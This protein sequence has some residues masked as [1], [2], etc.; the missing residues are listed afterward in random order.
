M[1]RQWEGKSR[2][3]SFGYKVFIWLLRHIGLEATYLLLC[4]VVLYFIPFAPR[5]T[6][7]AWVYS[8]SILGYGRMRAS[9]FLVRSYFAFGKSI[10]DK[11]AIGS[12]MEDRFSFE[13][14][15]HRMMLD[16]IE[17]GKGYVAIG[18]HVGS[19]QMGAPF[20]GKYGSRINVVMYDHER[21]AV[22]KVLEDHVQEDSFKIIPIADD[23]I[24]HVFEISN[25]LRNGELV[26][27]QGDRYM[28]E[29]RYLTAE[30]M[31]HDAKFPRGP[32]L[33]ASRLRVPV[34]FYF[35]M[36]E[37]GRRYRFHFFAPGAP[38]ASGVQNDGRPLREEELFTQ[39]VKS[40]ET[41]VRRYPEQWFNYY[42]FWNIYSSGKR[43]S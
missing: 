43:N 40:L 29:D 2:G 14:E 21:Q 37:R 27:F 12:G 42:D 3:G 39:Y 35:A 1:A 28:N 30:F 19:W 20:F 31:G 8:R 25:A 26:C 5:Q 9:W 22:K 41:M 33:L 7:S 34:V 13:F 38:G 4:L 11:V 16:L 23:G 32:F 17:S 15:N 18:A 36:R 10:I 24:S 6:R